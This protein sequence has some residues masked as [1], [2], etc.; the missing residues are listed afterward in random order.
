MKQTLVI[1]HDINYPRIYLLL[2][3]ICDGLHW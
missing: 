2:K 1:G 3:Y